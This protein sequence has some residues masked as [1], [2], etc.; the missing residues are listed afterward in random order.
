MLGAMSSSF[1]CTCTAVVLLFRAPALVGGGAASISPVTLADNVHEMTAD[2]AKVAGRA[3]SCGGCA[4]RES[5]S[6]KTMR[7]QSYGRVVSTIGPINSALLAGAVA[8]SVGLAM[9]H[10]LS[11]DVLLTLLYTILYLLA[12]PTAILVNKILMKDYGFGYPVL[13]SALGQT[14]TAICAY[15]A[16]RFCGVSIEAGR[17]VDKSSMAL[18]GGAS[19]LALV[20]GQ[21]PYLYL[22]VAF[23]QMLKAFSPAYMVIFLYCLG[24]E[25]PSRKVCVCGRK[26]ERRRLRC[27]MAVACA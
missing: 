27:P 10:F 15:A 23:I 4:R 7:L 13:V 3:P 14:V 8:L 5:V 9:Q 21:Y 17:N 2:N 22:T 16:V 11:R 12:S 19:A 26:R 25:Y 18:L 20:L 6:T 1:R 24:V